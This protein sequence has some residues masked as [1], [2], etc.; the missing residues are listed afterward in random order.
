ML[1]KKQP[2]KK[3]KLYHFSDFIK[4]FNF[5]DCR[6]AKI[7]GFTGWMYF[8]SDPVENDKKERVN[9][10]QNTLFLNSRCE[11]APEIKHHVLFIAN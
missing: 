4:D 3:R 6:R 1:V 7:D 10:F 8:L 5:Y 9:T 11:Y 2:N